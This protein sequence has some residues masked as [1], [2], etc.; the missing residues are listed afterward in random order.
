MLNIKGNFAHALYI[1]LEAGGK[2]AD[3][4]DR[5]SLARCVSQ[6]YTRDEVV[7]DIPKP[8]ISMVEADRRR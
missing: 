7:S 4:R 2:T 3:T 1:I 5:A 8:Q 6:G